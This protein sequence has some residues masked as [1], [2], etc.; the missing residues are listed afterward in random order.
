MD[1]ILNIIFPPK[2]M[3]CH[4]TGSLICPDCV[5]NCKKLKHQYCVVC[6]KPS[7]FGVTHNKCLTVIAPKQFISVY[8]YEGKVRQCI[9][10]SKYGTREF[11]ALKILTEH[12]VEL[13]KT[14]VVF[15][16]DHIVVPVPVSKTKLAFRG[17]N[18]AELIA[19]K[20]A[21]SLDLEMN[22][23]TLLRVKDTAGQFNYSRKDR[24]TNVAGAFEV[25]GRLTGKN[26]LVVDD[27]S[28][29]GAT[30]LEISKTLY[31]A[32]AAEVLCFTLSKKEI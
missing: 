8:S 12:A 17:F 11:M 25:K 20:V 10:N 15:F 16:N 5:K 14:K 31:K 9:K 1:N 30:L 7:P 2:C 24:F 18:Q 4:K 32:G 13:I 21:K 26:I 6:D 22:I 23:N 3:F 27:I 29:T 28:T 19:V